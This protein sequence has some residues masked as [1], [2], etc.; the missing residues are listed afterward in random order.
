M[1][2]FVQGY[3]AAH[4]AIAEMQAHHKY[5]YAACKY[6]VHMAMQHA[7]RFG[8][9]AI[10]TTFGDPFLFEEM[11]AVY[12]GLKFTYDIS[13]AV[14]SYLKSSSHMHGHQIEYL[15]HMEDDAEGGAGVAAGY[16]VQNYGQVVTI[17]VVV[18]SNANIK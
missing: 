18:Y 13:M 6:M 11:E 15:D 2:L 14:Y 16:V 12:Y 8:V 9:D 5:I 4:A 1:G 3:N 10:G 7:M 17:E